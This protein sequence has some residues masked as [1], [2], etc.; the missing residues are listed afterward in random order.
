LLSP[1]P[2]ELLRGLNI[3]FAWQIFMSGKLREGK[4]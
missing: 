1:I 2:F 3:V 4:Y